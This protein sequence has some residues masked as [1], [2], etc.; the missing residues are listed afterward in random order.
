[1]IFFITP[2]VCDV[3]GV[4]VLTQSVRL[5]VHVSRSQ[6]GTDRHMY[7]NFGMEVRWKDI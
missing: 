7:L 2:H 6:G 5:C 4:I 3:M 1:M